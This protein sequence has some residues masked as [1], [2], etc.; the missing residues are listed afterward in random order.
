M[1]GKK[2]ILGQPTFWRAIHALAT[3]TSASLQRV[4]PARRAT[5]RSYTACRVPIR[6]R[7]GIGKEWGGIR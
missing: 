7:V 3:L 4:R 1:R 5:P 2:G 6:K